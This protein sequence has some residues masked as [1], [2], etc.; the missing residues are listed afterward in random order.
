ME[1]GG[2]V[3]F[4][5]ASSALVAEALPQRKH[6]GVCLRLSAVTFAQSSLVAQAPRGM[7]APDGEGRPSRRRYQGRGAGAGDSLEF[8]TRGLLFDPAALE[9]LLVYHGQ[10]SG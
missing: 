2:G 9:V 5:P 7:L 10:A 8:R 4:S 3:E 6:Q 1:R